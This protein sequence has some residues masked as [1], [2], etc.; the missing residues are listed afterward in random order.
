MTFFQLF[1]YSSLYKEKLDSMDTQILPLTMYTS[2]LGC[3]VSD[4]LF[5]SCK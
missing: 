1:V 3:A 2:T 5:I 4:N